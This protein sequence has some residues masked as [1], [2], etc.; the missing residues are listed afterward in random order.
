MVY[1]Y[2]FCK[3]ILHHPDALIP[4]PVSN[5]LLTDRA[6]LLINKLAR[7]SNNEQHSDARRAAELVYKAMQPVSISE[8]L[9]SLLRDVKPDKSFD[10]VDVIAKKLPFLL[11]LKGFGCSDKEC[12]YVVTHIETLVKLLSPQKTTEE[13]NSINNIVDDFFSLSE[14][15]IARSDCFK[16]ITD[17]IKWTELYLCNLIGLLIQSYDAGWGLLCNSLMQFDKQVKSINLKEQDIDYFKRSVI[18]TVRFDPPVHL[19][20][21]IADAD[22]LLDGEAIKKGENILLILAAANVDPDVFNEPLTFDPLRA[23]NSAHITF[24]AGGHT[25]LAKYLMIDM[26]AEICRY[27]YSAFD[28]GIPTQAIEYEPKMNVRLLKRLLITLTDNNL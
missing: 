28:V 10:W 13:I 17:D 9:Q 8:L 21:R 20:K 11:I 12:D 4:Q 16:D 1:S 6:S 18:E 14:K 19:T 15:L 2:S 27:L 22:I 25:C 23:N 5:D 24:G 7:L 3:S 26:A